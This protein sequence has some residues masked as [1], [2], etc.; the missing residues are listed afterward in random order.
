MT[1]PYVDHIGIIATDLDQATEW[2]LPLFSDPTW[3]K[4]LPLAGL[5][6]AECC[7]AN[8]QIEPLQH[9]GADAESASRVMGESWASTSV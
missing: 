3:I 6:A 2:P 9:T 4:N 7:A 1:A 5:R 8:V